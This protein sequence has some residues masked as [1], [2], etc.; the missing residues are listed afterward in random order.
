MPIESGYAKYVC[1]REWSAHSDKKPAAN[2]IREDDAKAAAAWHE[3]AYVDEN[4]ASVTVTLCDECYKKYLVMK[5][6]HDEE[7]YGF[8][9]EGVQK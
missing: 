8:L 4:G 6:R 9:Y 2:F 1:N 3:I 5:Q 7:F